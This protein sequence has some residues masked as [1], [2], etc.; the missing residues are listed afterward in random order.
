MDTQEA[1]RR[2]LALELHDELGQVL[3]SIKMSLDMIPMLAPE[4]AREQYLRSQSL[5]SDLV[6]RVRR[7]ALELR[8]NTLD[9][10]GLLPA[11]RWLFKNYYEQTG[12][13]VSF[14]VSGIDRRFP[15]QIEIT[16][17]RITQEALTNIIRHAGS[18]NV[19]VDIWADRQSVN[20][21]IADQGKGFDP[22]IDRKGHESSGLSGMRERARLLGGDLVIESEPGSGTTIT[23]RLPARLPEIA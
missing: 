20:I 11:L 9:D 1:Q 4:A 7:M 19:R 15:P 13:K 23:A 8:P 2:T 21:Q 6:V 16:V 17:Y 10:L 3:N 18:K 12:E 14:E 22:Q 5:V